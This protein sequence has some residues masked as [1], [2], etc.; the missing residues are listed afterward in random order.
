VDQVGPQAR[1][2]HA[3]GEVGVVVLAA[4][5]L[6]DARHDPVGAL[7]V[8]QRQPL[9]EQRRHLPRQAHHRVEGAA[10]AGFP[11]GFEH[12][13][14]VFG[15]ERNLRRHAHAHRHA[16]FGERADGAQPPVRRRGAR[17]ELAGEFAVERGHGDVHG[18]QP[19]GRHRPDQVEVALDG[20]RLGDQRERVP[21]F[22]QQLDHRAR[23]PQLALD[24]LVAVGGG[25]DG[26]VARPVAL[27][28]EFGAQH[29]DEVALGDQLGLEVE[30]GREVEVA[31]RRA[32]ETIDAA[33]LAAPVRVERAV[34]G[35]VGRLVLG[36]HRLHVFEAHLGRERLQLG[37][38]GHAFLE[39]AP[40]VVVGGALV[41][42]EAVRQPRG[43]AAALD[44]VDGD[45]GSGHGESFAKAFTV[46]T[47]SI[48]VALACPRIFLFLY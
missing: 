46:H 25:A 13:L 1:A 29:L 22:L 20:A 6:V 4:T 32:R 8:V 41:T 39:R 23:E 27:A 10:R 2:L 24:G 31:V 9:L 3:R 45:L 26:D 35:D 37:G 34:E 30:A 5:H 40:A 28:A 16:R 38:L 21:R 19:V 12:L 11:G 36:E 43:R 42:G 7:R 18:G 15:D 48:P 44:G 47:Y 33:V 17:L 14:H